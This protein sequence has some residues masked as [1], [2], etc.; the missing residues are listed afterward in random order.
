MGTQ[1]GHYLLELQEDFPKFV[2]RTESRMAGLAPAIEQA[3]PFYLSD[4][5]LELVDNTDLG[6]P[7]HPRL[8]YENMCFEMAYQGSKV[9]TLA[10]EATVI[11]EDRGEYINY[12]IL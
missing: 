4:R 12:E 11:K 1:P 6:R 3:V 7:A 10:F 2:E 9:I 8:P 5:L